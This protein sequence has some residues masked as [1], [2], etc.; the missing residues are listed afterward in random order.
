MQ[1][2]DVR[3]DG[4]VQTAKNGRIRIRQKDDRTHSMLR[5]RH[6]KVCQTLE[7]RPAFAKN[8]ARAFWHQH[9]ADPVSASFR[10]NLDHVRV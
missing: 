4:A 1:L 9:K 8:I 10:G 2:E 7:T 3:H 6:Q 5:R